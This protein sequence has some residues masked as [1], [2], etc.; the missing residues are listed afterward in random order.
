M[1]QTKQIC[2]TQKLR[3]TPLDPGKATKGRHSPL[4]GIE[5][6]YRGKDP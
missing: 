3:Q 5:G 4:M 6:Y 1:T 2:T